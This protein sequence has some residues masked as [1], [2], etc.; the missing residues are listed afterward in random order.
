MTSDLDTSLYQPEIA[1]GFERFPPPEVAGGEVVRARALWGDYFQRVRSRYRRDWPRVER[2]QLTVESLIDS[3]AIPV[4]VYTPREVAGQGAGL[5]YLHGGAFYMGDLDWEEERC[6]V[7]AE[8]GQCVVVAVDY[9][10]P[11]EQPLPI[12][13]EDC[14]SALVWVAEHA[15]E[16]GVDAERLA[17]GGCSAG[18]ALSASVAQLCRDRGGPPLALQALI[19]PVLDASLSE[20]SLRALPAAELRDMELMWSHYT[21]GEGA[22]YAS[23]G[24]CE[25]LDGLAPAYIVAAELDALRDEA[26]SYARRLLAAGVSVE[27]HLVPGLPHAFELFVPEAEVSQRALEQQATDVARLLAGR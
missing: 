14:Y 21:G 3:H 18:G 20:P 2:R 6:L 12:P 7:L 25:I 22:A 24:Q 4:R 16:L 19:H 11:P 26:I 1:A 23:P 17:V 10:L 15:A 8:T 13:L 27:L 9:R 5:V